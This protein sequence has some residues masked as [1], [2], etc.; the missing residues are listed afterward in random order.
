MIKITA[1]DSLLLGITPALLCGYAEERGWT[2]EEHRHHWICRIRDYR[3]EVPR[4]DHADH[5]ARLVELL[6]A[7]AFEE[8]TEVY[9]PHWDEWVLDENSKAYVKDTELTQVIKLRL[10][11]EG[12]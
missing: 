2:W 6:E 10:T 5:K 8:T 11:P 4:L 3:I 7:F 1:P 12:A 9:N